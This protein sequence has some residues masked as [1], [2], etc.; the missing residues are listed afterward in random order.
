[1]SCDLTLSRGRICNRGIGG[2]DEIYIFPYVQ[3]ADSQ[4][5]RTA[6]TLTSF[7][8]TTI[9]R[10]YA[11][12]D[13]NFTDTEQED[14][15]GKSYK[16]ALSLTFPVLD[17]T[18]EFQKLIKMDY[19]MIVQDRNGIYR[20]LGAYKGGIFNNLKSE[21]GGAKAEFSGY[22]IDYEATEELPALFIDDLASAGFTVSSDNF[23]QL[24][25]D[26]LLLLEQNEFM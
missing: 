20:L 10:F 26:D 16:E 11:I 25:E 2:L 14:D 8:A 23:L 6:L 24:E 19:R 1:M 13:P 5:V 9:Y 4:I 17:S 3:Y 15:G 7:P 18:N 21:T 12:A 22:T